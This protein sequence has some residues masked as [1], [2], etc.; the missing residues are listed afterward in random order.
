LDPA[1][2]NYY[3]KITL[4]YLARSFLLDQYKYVTNLN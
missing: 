1:D 4:I 3:Q 2:P